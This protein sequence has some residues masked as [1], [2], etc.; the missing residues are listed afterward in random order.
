MKEIEIF[1]PGTIANISCGFDVLGCCLDSVGDHMSLR[2]TIEKGIR[3]SRITGVDLPLDPEKNVAGAAIKALL[4]ALNQPVGFGFEVEMTKNIKPGSGI[5]SSAASAAGAVFGVNE[6]LGRPFSAQELIPFAAEGERL[7]CGSPIADN[8]GPALLGGFTLVQTN[9]PLRVLKLPVITGLYA[10]I[11]HPQIE[12]KTADSR[13]ILPTEVPL[14]DAIQQWANVGTLVHAL[15][16]N[17]TELFALSLHDHI[18]EPHRSKL[19]PKFDS[20]KEAALKNGALG[21][22]ISGSGPS[23]YAFSKDLY[24]A[25]KVEVEFS[26]IYSKT[27][28]PFH[29]YVSGINEKGIK[30]IRTEE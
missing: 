17:D 29:T 21:C 4:N 6:L 13:A 20:I 30:I 1:S 15:H 28:I 18:V 10:T 23:I 14:K 25:E 26:K 16:E 7:A 12:I 24:T 27:T 11:I 22:G 5:G 9:T 3:I 8:V 2:K 19:I